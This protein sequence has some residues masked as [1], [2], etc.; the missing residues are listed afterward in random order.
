MCKC[1]PNIDDQDSE[2]SG[3]YLSEVLWV[4]FKIGNTIFINDF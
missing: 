4:L 1:G 3:M 2:K